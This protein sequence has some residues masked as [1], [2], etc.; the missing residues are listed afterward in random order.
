MTNRNKDII[1]ID[2]YLPGEKYISNNEIIKN[3]QSISN[4]KISQ[5]EINKFRAS[6]IKS[7]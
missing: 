6:F 2:K 4:T 7:K 5:N 3:F 1:C